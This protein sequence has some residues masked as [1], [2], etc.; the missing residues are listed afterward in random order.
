MPLATSPDTGRPAP[1]TSLPSIVMFEELLT[2]MPSSI[3]SATWN[4]PD[5]HPRHGRPE[6]PSV[7]TLDRD[8][9]ARRGLD[10]DRRR[11]VPELAT[12][13]TSA[14]VPPKTRTVSP[15][16]ARS[17]PSLIVHSGSV[18]V[19]GPPSEQLAFSRST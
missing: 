3:V 13:T 18:S 16:T 14:Y 15:A 10:H 19:A 2:R 8:R 11:E 9:L 12:S 1:L 4:P 7:A 5:G 6:N 17:A